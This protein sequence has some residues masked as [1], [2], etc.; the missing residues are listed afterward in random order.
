M[1]DETV[2]PLNPAFDLRKAELRELESRLKAAGG[3]GIPP[4]MEARVAKLE[5]HVDHI[6]A[7]L[8][9]LGAVPTDLAVL[10]TRV[11]H[12]PTKGFILTSAI[13]TVAAI[14]GLLTILSR[15]GV[16]SAN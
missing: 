11:D 9:K 14:V 4:D 12:L 10:K 5:A 2:V 15:M 16:L 8:G 6:R 7:D 3:G 13:S 1:T